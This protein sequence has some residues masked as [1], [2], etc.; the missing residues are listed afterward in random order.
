[1]VDIGLNAVLAFDPS[2]CTDTTVTSAWASLSARFFSRLIRANIFVP[3]IVILVILPFF[4]RRLKWARWV[5]LALL[6]GFV[7]I[8]TTGFVEFGD[9]TLTHFLPADTGEPAE[10]IVVLGRGGDLNKSR[11][12]AAYELW[13]RDRAP[14]IFASGYGDSHSIVK[15]LSQRGVP[16]TALDHDSCSRTTEENAEK[17]AAI[18]RPRGIQ[19]II[20]VTDSPHMMRSLLTFRSFGFNVIPHTTEIP[21]SLG[22]SKRRFMV[23][24][25]WAGLI[26]YG[27]RGRYF[28][29]EEWQTAAVSFPTTVNSMSREG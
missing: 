18:L 26:G 27:I 21:A 4:L 22:I 10:A 7:L 17:T 2:L 12:D 16:S 14:L 28:P 11:V 5:S 9:R 20:L 29:R 6:V 13:Q 1:M 19:K 23:L 3:G 25:E 15:Q 24:R 8:K